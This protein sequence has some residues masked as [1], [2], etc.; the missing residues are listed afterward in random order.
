MVKIGK[1]ALKDLVQDKLD[2]KSTANCLF[3]QLNR[4]A[5]DMIIHPKKILSSGFL[6][7]LKYILASTRENHYLNLCLY[8]RNGEL[9]IKKNS[10][11]SDEAMEYIGIFY[12]RNKYDADEKLE[13]GAISEYLHLKKL[14]SILPDNVAKPFVMI[15]DQF[16]LFGGYLLENIPGPTLRDVLSLEFYERYG[17]GY[18]ID[19]SNQLKCI[20]SKL[21]AAGITHGDIKDDNIMVAY[22]NKL[23]LIDPLPFCPFADK[24]LASIEDERTY[25]VI[26]RLEK[27]AR[28]LLP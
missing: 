12:K 1:R 10:L 24:T 16:N 19:L 21:H 17:S 7:R 20:I 23:K 26:D 25:E 13:S 28:K 9:Y 11:P 15:L 4:T 2:I 18:F 22:G 3:S 14:H 8:K 6:I 27:K 5:L